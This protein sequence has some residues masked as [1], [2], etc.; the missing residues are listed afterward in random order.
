MLHIDRVIHMPMTDLTTRI[1]TETMDRLER[2]ARSEGTTA[3]GIAS[4]ALKAVIED[5]EYTRSLIDRADADFAAGRFVSAEAVDDWMEKWGKGEDLPF[6]Q[7]D[8]KAP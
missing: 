2:I 4:R 1:D 6:P 7:P 3:S 5:R 8:T